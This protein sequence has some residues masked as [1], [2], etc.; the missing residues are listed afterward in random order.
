VNLTEK[1]EAMEKVVAQAR[2]AG[3]RF[4]DG[5]MV[6]LRSMGPASVVKTSRA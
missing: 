1:R 3:L 6:Q 4:Y 2:Q 5:L